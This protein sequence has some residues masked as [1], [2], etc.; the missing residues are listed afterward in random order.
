M[1]NTST[2]LAIVQFAGTVAVVGLLVWFAPLAAVIALVGWMAFHLAVTRRV[3]VVQPVLAGTIPTPANNDSR[4]Q[5]NVIAL[6]AAAAA[7]AASIPFLL[8]KVTWFAVVFGAG[9]VA[10][11]V[12]AMGKR[13]PAS[14]PTRYALRG[15]A[16][17]GAALV[18]LTLSG[19]FLN[20][21][22]TLYAAAASTNTGT[23]WSIKQFQARLPCVGA[24]AYPARE[25]QDLY[26]IDVSGFYTSKSCLITSAEGARPVVFV[27]AESP[28]ALTALFDSGIIEVG[29]LDDDQL[30]MQR[31]GAVAVIASDAASAKLLRETGT[32]PVSLQAQKP[33]VAL[34]NIPGDLG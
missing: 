6:A 20:P 18:I 9:A 10:L 19:L 29:T 33:R 26:F 14:T 4:A 7:V 11:S 8:G 27:Q 28:Q 5:T 31:D 15:T 32:A 22:V 34:A 2:G 21:P 17:F 12:I 16:V 1:R 30:S 23:F 24:A 3:R 13:A 25:N